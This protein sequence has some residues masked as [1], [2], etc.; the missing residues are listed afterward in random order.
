MGKIAFVFSGQGAQYSGMGKS[1]Y[2]ADGKVKALYESAEQIRPGTM[3]QSFSGTAEEL[4]QTVNTQ[5]CMYLTELAAATALNSRG[6]FA[7][8]TAGFSLGEIAA[9][10][11]SGAYSVSDG[12]KI[13]IQRAKFMEEAAKQHDTAMCA[14]LRLDSETVKNTVKEYDSLYAVNFNCP[15]QTVVS[16]IKSSIEKYSA[17]VK[18]LG[19]R[20]VPLAVSAAFHSPFMAEAADNF[21][22]EL[23]KYDI[24]TPELPV[25][26]NLTAKPYGDDVLSTLSQQMKS[27]VKWQETV[28][29]MIN[30]GFTDFIE[31]GPGKTLCGLISKISKDV[32]TYSVENEETL[33]E[34]VQAVKENA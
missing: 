9:L 7:E 8:G 4:K 31:V 12:F 21:A 30:D 5:P 2:D 22:R 32:H 23:A 3:N 19:G 17:E 34:T 6:I 28:E 25:Y 26:A 27:P 11:Y 1:L 18:A 14:V 20:A 24:T 10:A 13:V 29:N 33:L 16:G 15:G